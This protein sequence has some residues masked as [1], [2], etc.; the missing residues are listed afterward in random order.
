MKTQTLFTGDEMQQS[1]RT[2]LAGAV[3]T[4]AS[5]PLLAML[6]RSFA[7]FGAEAGLG[8]LSPDDTTAKALGFCLNADQP[9]KQCA[10]RKTKDKQGQYCTLCQLYTKFQGSGKDEM[11]KC[12][13]LT[14]G[15]V[16]AHGWCSSWVKRP[17]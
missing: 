3:F 2:F 14:K 8:P 6:G 5:L 1:R 7:A 4:L 10:T 9:T 16:P 13:V 15:L 12:I 11:G 17:S